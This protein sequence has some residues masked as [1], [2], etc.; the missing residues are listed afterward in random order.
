MSDLLMLHFCVSYILTDTFYEN[1]FKSQF[2]LKLKEITF[3]SFFLCKM[4][5]FLIYVTLDHKTIDV[6]FVMIGQYLA[7]IQLFENL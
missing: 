6:C 3:Y 7:D 2:T 1:M 5:Y 4:S